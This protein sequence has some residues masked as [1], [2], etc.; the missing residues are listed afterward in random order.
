MGI[1]PLYFSTFYGVDPGILDEYGAF[2]ISLES[3]LPVFIDPFLIFNS[4]E[5]EHTAL[6]DRIIEYLR[7]L[8]DRS[9]SDIADQGALRYLYCFPEVK[10]NWLGFTSMGNQGSGLGIQFARALSA[11]LGS[12]FSNFGEEKVTQGS[13][14]EKVSLIREGVGRDNISD[15]ATNL[16][17][18]YLLEYTQKFARQHI[19]SDM[20]R[21]FRV[22]KVTFNYQTESWTDGTYTLPEY[23]DDFI[24]LTPS[25]LLTRDDTW[26]NSS[27]LINGFDRIPLAISD[28]ELRSQ[29]SSYFTK[30]LG[31]EDSRK[32]RAA[33]AYATIRRYPEVVDYYIRIKEDTGDEAAALSASK[34]AQVQEYYREGVIELSEELADKTQFYQV[35]TRSYNEALR[36]AQYFR[37]YIENQDG[38][39]LLNNPNFKPS[40]EKQVQLAFGLVWFGTRFDVNRE[41]NNGRGPV[42]FKISA[43]AHDKS[44]IEFKLAS[45]TRLKQ[46]LLKQVEIY[47]AA[48][49][50]P[51]AVK[52]IL[53]YTEMDQAR[54][55]AILSELG[56]SNDESIIVVDARADN[57]P[58]ASKA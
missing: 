25:G 30:R 50:T 15:F 23:R 39:L 31:Q 54:I 40:N 58:S 43:S 20:L 7:Y 21:D 14:L 10:Q 11:G 5:P 9:A 46:N 2:D 53:C 45:N 28:G 57:K 32:A 12:I 17:K 35:G 26:I 37:Y 44:L 24:L 48:N 33:A 16:I 13:H 47:K 18:D 22:R 56:L 51:H 1:M 52:I 6:H 38:Y 55:A 27:D 8:K 36:R 42:D 29:V 49:C 3:D 34:V 4:A 41:P 19:S